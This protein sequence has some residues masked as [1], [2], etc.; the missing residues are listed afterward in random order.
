M[1]PDLPRR[2]RGRARALSR[3][4]HSPADAWL[5]TRMVGWR[6]VVPVLKRLLPLP[7]LARL[8]WAGTARAPRDRTREERV[9]ALAQAVSGP[10]GSRVLDNCLDRSLI[11]Y[12]FLSKA[13]AEPELVVGVARD[14]DGVR[15]HTW[16]RID[17][18]P[19]KEPANSLEG[20]EELTAF[21]AYGQ[22]IASGAPSRGHATMPP[23]P[24]RSP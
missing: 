24:D 7:R 23:R 4:V 20:F 11:A 1:T 15:G 2:I 8:T 14:D 9:M 17:G 19:F 6:L 16:I 22:V 10:H 3:S 21:G 13:G 5:A 12:R 18:A